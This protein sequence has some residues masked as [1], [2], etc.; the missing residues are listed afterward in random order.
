M[1][2][3]QPKKIYHHRDM[4]MK[5][6]RG[7]VHL[8]FMKNGIN[9]CV[10]QCV[11]AFAFCMVSPCLWG[12][13]RQVITQ[14]TEWLMFTSNMKL[15]KHIGFTFDAQFRFSQR[16]EA[17][18]HFVRNGLDVYVSD[19]FSFVP[20][21][22]MYVWNYRYGERPPAFADNEHRLWQQVFY[23]HPVGKW[24]LN[25]RLRLEQRLIQLHDANTGEDKGYDIFR[26]RLRYRVVS[27]VP[28]RGAAI[29]PKSFFA[30]VMNECFYSWG[31]D[32]TTDEIDQNRFFTGVGYQVSKDFFVWPGLFYQYLLR[33]NGALQEN[34]VGFLIWVSYNIDFAKRE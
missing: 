19:K 34:N 3:V 4:N 32:V 17:M 30:G 18:Q 14:P 16:F 10:V 12:Q 22:Y 23:K 26:N 28:L 6:A 33:S 13:P 8:C 11:L 15:S 20:I 21:G 1:R 24:R 29:V 31:K 7:L 25:H 9:R 2:N 5:H 27:Q